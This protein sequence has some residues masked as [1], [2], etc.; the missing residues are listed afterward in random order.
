MGEQDLLDKA[1]KAQFIMGR[2]D[3]SDYIR[4]VTFMSVENMCGIPTNQPV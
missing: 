4:R 1:H 3:K 2:M